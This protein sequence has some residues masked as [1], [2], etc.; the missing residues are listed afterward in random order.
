MV[1]VPFGSLSTLISVPKLLRLEHTFQHWLFHYHSMKP[2]REHD[3][4]DC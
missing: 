4:R 1:V 2:V 3:Q